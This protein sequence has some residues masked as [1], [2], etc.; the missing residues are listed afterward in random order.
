ME[1]FMATTAG[2]VN[3]PRSRRWLWI[4]GTIVILVI[5]GF[6]LAPRLLGDRLPA[7][8]SAN[9]DAAQTVTATPE[10][11]TLTVTGSGT[12]TAIQSREL[13]PEVTGVVETVVSAGTRV[14]AGDVLV[15]LSTDTF[16]RSVRDAQFAL[17]QAE[18][19]RGST[20]STQADN[21]VTLQESIAN[22]Q[23]TIANA[24]RDVQTKLTDLNLK[25]RLVTVGGES[26]EAVRLAQND[27]D[28]AVA[29]LEQAR[30]NLQTLQESQVY[31]GSSNEQTLRNSDLAIEAARNS[32]EKAQEDLTKTTIVAPFDGVV[33]VVNV[34]TGS[35]VNTSTAMVTVIDDSKIELPAEIDET[36]ISKV[37]LGQKATVTLDAL[38]GETFEGEVTEVAAAARIVS[39]IPIFDVTIL[40]D[41]SAG[42]LRDGMSAEADIT[43]QEVDNT[44]TVPSRAVTT[45]DDKSSVELLQADGSAQSV[46]VQVVATEGLDSIIQGEIPAGSKVVTT[47]RV[48]STSNAGPFGG[49]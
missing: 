48:A 20:A 27:Y 42:R 46:E 41:N 44:I 4:V 12:L 39:N 19:Q 16:E 29:T 14:N 33:S 25:Q 37:Q 28:T 40:L 18:A 49:E 45:A 10:P 8:G 7:R 5:A 30:L 11:Y 36:E 24:E 6:F 35:I 32:L 1:V 13:A 26:S 17:E 9:A 22:A 2:K 47:A 38:T 34:K 3:K 43:I 31:R 15:Q 21:N 23:T